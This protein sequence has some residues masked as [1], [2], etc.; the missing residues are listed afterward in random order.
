M[1]VGSG[2]NGIRVQADGHSWIAIV[3]EELELVRDFSGQPSAE[4]HVPPG[5]YEIR[6][7]GRLR[8]AET[9]HREPPS[10]PLPEFLGSTADLPTLFEAIDT[11]VLRLDIDAPSH[12]PA[13]GMPQLPA[14]GAAFCAVTVRKA[15]PDGTLLKGRGHTDQVFLRSTGG[16]LL[17]ADTDARVSSIRLKSGRAA[18]RLV[19]ERTPRLVTVYAFTAGSGPRAEIQAE[20]T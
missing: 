14:D 19:A 13:D 17:A 6:T 11:T 1:E 2:Q 3:G 15:T 18:F 10:L 12:H 5:A 16:T 8:G 4:F 7:D 9:I 20:F